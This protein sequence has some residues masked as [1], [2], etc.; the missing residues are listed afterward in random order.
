MD[1]ASKD[2]VE[3]AT[4]EPALAGSIKASALGPSG[5]ARWGVRQDLGGG[6]EVGSGGE[7]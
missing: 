6:V 2:V 7:G 5:Q 3:M 1:A 4:V